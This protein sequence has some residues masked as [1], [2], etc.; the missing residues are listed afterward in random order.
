MV[1]AADLGQLYRNCRHADAGGHDAAA[2]ME[3]AGPI[4][5]PVHPLEWR[6]T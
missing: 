6:T 4:I 2:I 1:A 5:W 3:L